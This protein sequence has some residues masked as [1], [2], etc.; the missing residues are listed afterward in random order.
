MDA[1]C[2]DFNVL[3]TIGSGAQGTVVL[4]ENK[5]T[6][7]T[8]AIKMFQLAHKTQKLGFMN[9]VEAIARLKKCPETITTYRSFVSDDNGIVVMEAMK[10]DLL[11]II[12]NQ[13]IT[14][15]EAANIFQNICKAIKFMHDLDM[16]HLDVKPDNILLD[17]DGNSKLCDFGN[18]VTTGPNQEVK[19]RR[20]TESYIAPEICTGKFFCPKKAD[21]WSLGVTLHTILTGCLPFKN[22]TPNVLCEA[23]L[24]NPNLS[25]HAINLLSKILVIDPSDRYTIDQVLEHRFFEFNKTNKPSKFNPFARIKNKLYRISKN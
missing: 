25:I 12:L 20:G 18:T 14:E 10:C 19:G 1:I 21:V 17:F 11:D 9:E 13:S 2:K 23:Y 6:Q 8:V 16:A 5:R 24:T 7:A 22:D 4:A 15:Q 3:K